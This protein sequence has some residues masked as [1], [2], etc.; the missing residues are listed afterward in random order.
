MHR[1]WEYTYFSTFGDHLRFFTLFNFTKFD[2]TRCN[3]GF[4]FLILFIY[5][6]ARNASIAICHLS[7]DK[8]I[9]IIVLYFPN[10]HCLSINYQQESVATRPHAWVVSRNNTLGMSAERGYSSFVLFA[11][12]ANRHY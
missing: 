3:N 1:M 6:T 10:K 2:V 7:F 9:F 5:F 4:C 12:I 11:A 8:S